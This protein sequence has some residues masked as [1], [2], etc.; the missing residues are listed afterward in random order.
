MSI[1]ITY[2]FLQRGHHGLGEKCYLYILIMG[3]LTLIIMSSKI[4]TKVCKEY[5]RFICAQVMASS[6]EFDFL[7]HYELPDA[8][9][10]PYVDK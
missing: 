6:R 9:L 7:H 3:Y 1:V 2:N 4:F 8:Q 5:F 10:A